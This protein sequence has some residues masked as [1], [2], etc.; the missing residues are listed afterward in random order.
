MMNNEQLTRLKE[1]YNAKASRV[2]KMYDDAV[3]KIIEPGLYQVV[4]TDFGGMRDYVKFN[5]KITKPIH[6][7]DLTIT[8]IEKNGYMSPWNYLN[9]RSWEPDEYFV[10]I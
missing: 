5:I 10:T 9:I 8:L 7:R 2:Q 4:E 6:M 1:R 3:D